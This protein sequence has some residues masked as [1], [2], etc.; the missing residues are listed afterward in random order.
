MRDALRRVVPVNDADRRMDLDS[1]GRKR[2]AR[3]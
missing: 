3:L 2:A 1:R